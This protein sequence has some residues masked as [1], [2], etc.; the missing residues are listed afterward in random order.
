LSIPE[1]IIASVK[2]DL[3]KITFDNSYQ[4]TF[5]PAYTGYL[6]SNSVN[7]DL[8][9]FYFLK[10]SDTI[11]QVSAYNYG[12]IHTELEI[13]VQ[14]SANTKEGALTSKC[15][16]ILNDLVKWKNTDCTIG[17]I[18]NVDFLYIQNQHRVFDW[19]QNT[20]TAK[21][22]ILIQYKDSI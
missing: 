4:N 9:P 3:A 17:T 14:F 10:D 2:T 8:K 13:A 19:A 5:L 6:P 20:G 22:V 11:V 15:E 1:S 21:I 18:A 16:S 7:E 12:I